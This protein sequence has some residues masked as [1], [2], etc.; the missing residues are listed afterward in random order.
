[1]NN[2]SD[3]V[4]SFR[5]PPLPF[6]VES[7]KTLYTIGEQHPSRHRLGMFD[8]LLVHYG[9]LHIGEDNRQWALTAGQ[10]LL[11]LPE[12][13]HYAVKPCEEETLFYWIHFEAIGDW[14]ESAA[15][16]GW[17][18]APAPTTTALESAAAGI[19]APYA[20]PSPYTIN[21]PKHTS[22]AAPKQTFAQLDRLLL[23]HQERRSESFWEQQQLFQQLLRMFDEGQ[24]TTFASPAL[25]VAERVEAYIKQHYADEINNAV[26]GEALHFHPGYLVRCMKEIFHCTPMD[27]LL[28]YR[29]ERAKLLL[30]KTEQPIAVIAEAVGFHQTPYFSVCFKKQTGLS[31]LQYRKQFMH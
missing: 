24:R 30:L 14:T 11:L 10:T 22:L 12:R 25:A 6:Y 19:D 28:Y 13:Y 1:M 15:Q 3:P 26:L 29:I 20:T 21:V 27:Y 8:L 9:T 31:P 7:G 2:Q 5:M 18:P 16:Q 4:V 17:A 23:L